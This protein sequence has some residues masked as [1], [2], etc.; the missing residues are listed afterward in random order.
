MD[1]FSARTSI[2]VVDAGERI[3]NENFLSI[4]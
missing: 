3:A 1:F 2:E 4:L